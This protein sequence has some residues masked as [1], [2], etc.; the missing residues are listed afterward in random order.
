MNYFLKSAKFADCME[1][2]FDKMVERLL[3]AQYWVIDMLPMQVPQGSA[4]QF[5]AV[6]QYYLQEPQHGRLCRQFAD[7][8]LRLNCYHDLHVNH[9]DEWV[10]NPAPATLVEW[11]TDALYH[12]HLCGLI[13]EGTALITASSGDTHL[14]LYNPTPALLEL[15]GQLAT[16]AGL[17]LWQPKVNQ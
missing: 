5:F 1:Q 9:G 7:V 13:D 3:E 12:G 8:L 10:K 16:A 4:G 11:L 17:F 2:D 15:A 6:E 14:T